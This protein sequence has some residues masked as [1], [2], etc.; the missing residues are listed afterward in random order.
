MRTVRKLTGGVGALV[1][2]LGIS[3]CSGSG[4][5]GG[6]GPDGGGRSLSF[7]Y[8]PEP[9]SLVPQEDVGS[10]IAMA[11]CANL[12][13]F[14]S[15][16]HELEPLAAKSVTSPDAQHWTIKLREGWTFQD[17]SPVTAHSFA[18]AWNKAAYGPNAWLGNGMFVAFKGYAA[19][20]PEDG[21]KPETDTLS[22]VKVVDK[23]TIKVTTNRPNVDLPKILSTNPTCPLPK[24]AFT[25]PEGYE[26]HPVGNGPYRFVSWQHNQQVVLEKWKGFK[27]GKEFTGGADRLVAKVYTSVESA[28]TDLTAGNLDLIRNVP[29]EMATKA[30]GQLPERS[31]FTLEEQG[32][33]SSLTVPSYVDYLKDPRLRKALS[34]GIDRKSIASSLLKGDAQPADSLVTPDL[35]SYRKGA[36]T[37]CT[38]DPE[39][40]RQLIKEAGGFSQP[41]RLFYTS[42]KD[43]QLV[44]AIYNQWQQNLGIKVKLMPQQGTAL[45]DLYNKGKLTGVAY[46]LW[47]WSYPSPDQYLGQY[48]TGGDGNI[49]NRYSNPTVDKLLRRAHGE[50]DDATRQDL[51]YRAEQ[52][53]LEDM[54]S[55]PLFYPAQYGLQSKCAQIRTAPGDLQYYRADY[56]C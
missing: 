4:A 31:L 42:G 45:S 38:F 55:I 33:A 47:G 46:S 53:V 34:L 30:R 28:Y 36:C 49:Y 50:Q 40:A 16:T 24:Q 19:L 20:N 5:D 54:P 9:K 14:N 29:I 26:Q 37:A 7:Y 12:M 17:G 32:Q 44:K 6:T 18:D 2:A 52:A 8:G 41:V 39:K 21:S 22:G 27:G 56:V 25:D 10:Q 43:D 11:M 23:H 13:E 48:R 35:E 15:K 3:A 1:L 51:Y